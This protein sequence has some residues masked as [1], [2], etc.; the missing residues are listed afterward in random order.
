MNQDA[1]ITQDWSLSCYT[2]FATKSLIGATTEAA[3]LEDALL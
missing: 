1:K 2:T 3:K